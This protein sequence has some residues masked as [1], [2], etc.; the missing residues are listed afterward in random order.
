[1]N[2]RLIVVIAGY[3]AIIA[4]ARIVNLPDWAY[5]VVFFGIVFYW[6]IKHYWFNSEVSYYGKK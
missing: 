6:I 4:L 3:F 2:V 1:M 5:W